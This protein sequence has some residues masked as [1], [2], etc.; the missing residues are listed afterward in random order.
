MRQLPVDK[1][2]PRV[3][4]QQDRNLNAN[5]NDYVDELDREMKD[6]EESL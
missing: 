6:L 3:A 5:N 2:K 4:Y 1:Q